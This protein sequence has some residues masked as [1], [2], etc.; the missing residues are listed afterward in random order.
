ML[1]KFTSFSGNI[2]S[3]PNGDLNRIFDPSYDVPSSIKTIARTE[4]GFILSSDVS[5]TKQFNSLSFT[6]TSNL[7]G[8]ATITIT[9]SEN[10][11][12][13]IEAYRS[14]IQPRNPINIVSHD[15]NF[16]ATNIRWH[17]PSPAR[18]VQVNWSGSA[19][20]L[21]SFASL[22]FRVSRQRHLTNRFLVSPL[23]STP[24]TNFSV[25]LVMAD[26]RTSKPVPISKYSELRG[27]VGSLD[28][29]WNSSIPDGGQ[30]HPI[31]QTVRVPISDFDG[32][33]LT[34]VSGVRFIFNDNRIG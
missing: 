27:P 9:C 4:R 3:S 7:C 32:A 18:Y 34:Q 11:T 19:S 24:I 16:V 29:P 6:Q 33:D 17:S 20:S 12:S 2:G 14:T 10:D 30:L 1:L 21:T 8:V 26:G 13:R 31:L 22:D 5:Q 23:N 15:E 28:N 25:Q